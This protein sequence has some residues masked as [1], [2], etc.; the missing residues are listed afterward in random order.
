[1]MKEVRQSHNYIEILPNGVELEMIYIPGGTFMMGTDDAEIER[2]CKQYVCN[3]F[4]SEAPQ[5]QVTVKPFYLDK[6]Q[7]TQLQ[8][9]AIMDKNPSHFKNGGNYPVE[10][11]SWHD[12]IAFCK[13]LSK[14]SGK[15]YSLPSE[16]QWEYACR[17]VTSYQLSVTQYYYGNDE[18]K[19]KDYGWYSNN[20]GSQTHEVGKKIAN[21]FGLYDMMG[22][23]W[24]WCYDNRHKNYKK[25]LKNCEP[26]IETIDNIMRIMRGGAWYSESSCCRCAYRVWNNSDLNDNLVGFRVFC[27][28]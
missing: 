6:Y 9:Q 24:E 8:Y 12:A 21:N 10:C 13:K 15:Q 18:S 4:K 22:N 16:A 7:V 27:A 19:L 23:L 20:S 3:Y 5:H 26:W 25:A 2:L 11:V 14:I 28:S 17:G 1:M